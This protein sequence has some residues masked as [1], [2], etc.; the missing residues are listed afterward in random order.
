MIRDLLDQPSLW[1]DYRFYPDA[2]TYGV[3]VRRDAPASLREDFAARF[4]ALYPDVVI[5]EYEA[6]RAPP[7]P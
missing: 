2:F 3:A 4:R 6:E 5:E 7:A 1:R